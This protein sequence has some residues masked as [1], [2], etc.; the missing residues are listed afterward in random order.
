MKATLSG[1]VT[2]F[3]ATPPAQKHFPGLKYPG[4]CHEEGRADR[5]KWG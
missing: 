4:H 2:T 5:D 3:T 1:S